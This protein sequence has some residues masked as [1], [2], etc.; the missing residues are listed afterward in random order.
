[1]ANLPFLM[2]VLVICLSA[3]PMKMYVLFP[4]RLFHLLTDQLKLQQLNSWTADRARIIK[5]TWLK[6]TGTRNSVRAQKNCWPST[7]QADGSISVRRKL[8]DTL[9]LETWCRGCSPQPPPATPAVGSSSSIQLSLFL[10]SIIIYSFHNFYLIHRK[11]W[12]KE[13]KQWK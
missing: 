2:I 13:E 10:Y 8:V 1:M 4:Y 6:S 12:K 9:Y 7:S 5:R 3:C 11:K